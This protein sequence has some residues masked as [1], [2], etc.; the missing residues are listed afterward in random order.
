MP[1]LERQRK[2]SKA[3]LDSQA[4]S[5]T[6]RGR[7]TAQTRRGPREEGAGA[8]LGSRRRSRP[9]LARLRAGKGER[10]Q[11]SA[12][13]AE[14]AEG[15]IPR[16]ARGTAGPPDPKTSPGRRRDSRCRCPAPFPRP[17][18]RSSRC[19]SGSPARQGPR[20]GQCAGGRR[21]L[22]VLGWPWGRRPWMAASRVRPARPP[23]AA[24]PAAE[25]GALVLP[26]VPGS[27]AARLQPRQAPRHPG[28]GGLRS[29]SPVRIN[30]DAALTAPGDTHRRHLGVSPAKE[31]TVLP[32]KRKKVALPALESGREEAPTPQSASAWAPRPA[33]LEPPPAGQAGNCT[34]GLRPSP[35]LGAAGAPVSQQSRDVSLVSP[36]Q[37]RAR[38]PQ[39]LSLHKLPYSCLALVRTLRLPHVAGPR[40]ARPPPAP[41]APLWPGLLRREGSRAGP[42]LGPTPSRPRAFALVVQCPV[43]S[44]ARVLPGRTVAPGRVGQQLKASGDW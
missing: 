42:Q 17:V 30:K 14:G 20:Q 40:A 10:E 6:R 36:R 11:G 27:G 4:P 28:A 13:P 7:P 44:P 34:R 3:Q 31:G 23:I 21:P 39:A 33:G 35:A 8:N 43:C 12:R 22:G 24:R 15:H 2:T 41:L 29:A 19:P 5:L 32:R 37:A 38:D 16:H 25:G 18:L 1:S 26:S 9:G